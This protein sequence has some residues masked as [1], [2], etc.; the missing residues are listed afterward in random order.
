M[1][2]SMICYEDQTTPQECPYGH[3]TRIVTGGAGG[4]A[5]VHVVEVTEGGS[6]SHREYDEVYYVLS[7]QG[8]LELGDEHHSLR[9]GAVAVI[10]AGTQHA[11]HAAPGQILKFIIFGTPAM[12]MNDPRSLPQHA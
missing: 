1:K 7:G 10:P 11:L 5:N 3:T 8:V 12:A 6:H 4:V 2:S 9:P